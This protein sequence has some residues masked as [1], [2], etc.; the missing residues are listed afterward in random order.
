MLNS[1]VLFLFGEKIGLSSQACS[2]FGK[3]AIAPAI[4]IVLFSQRQGPWLGRIGM[5]IYNIFSTVFYLGDVL[6]YLRIMALGMLGG[7]LAVA[8]NLMAGIAGKVPYAGIVLVV[9][10]LIG[11]HTLNALLSAIGAFVHTIRLQFVEFFPKFLSGGGQ[12]F[13]PLTKEYKY[14]YMN[15]K[16]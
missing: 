4:V 8:I 12:L 9:L 2:V 15:V 3:V 6:S 16:K 10:V 7:G 5:G 11:G 13:E 1:L 14:V